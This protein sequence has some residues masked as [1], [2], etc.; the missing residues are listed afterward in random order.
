M[1][2]GR[3]NPLPSI[4]KQRSLVASGE[5]STCLASI[6]WTIDQGDGSGVKICAPWRRRQLV[7]RR[8]SYLSPVQ[9]RECRRPRSS[10]CT[11]ALGWKR[12]THH[13]LSPRSSPGCSAT[14]RRPSRPALLLVE[15][16]AGRRVWLRRW[17]AKDPAG[18]PRAWVAYAFAGVPD[19]M[20]LRS[21]EYAAFVLQ[22]DAP[23]PEPCAPSRF[24][25]PRRHRVQRPGT[26]TTARADD[27][28]GSGNSSRAPSYHEPG[29]HPH[30]PHRGG[31]P[32]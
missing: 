31:D 32:P 5:G 10:I 14:R 2:A 20:P 6:P 29:L 3:S 11:M 12:S 28:R 17:L 25:C 4:G 8:W 15:S 1:S 27:A 16:A 30:A 9:Y 7:M 24:A 26:S 13:L 22:P 23:E 21:D 19:W 18:T